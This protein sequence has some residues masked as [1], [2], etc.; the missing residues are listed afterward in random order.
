MRLFLLSLGIL[1]GTAVIG[2]VTIRMVA[3]AAAGAL[4]RLPRGLWLSTLVLL[5][6]SAT[7]EG[8]LRA[9]RQDLQARLRAC[10]TATAFLG[11]NFLAVQAACWVAWA[12]PMREALRGAGQVYLLTGFYVLTGLHGLHVTGG[13]LPLL[14][15]TRR[16]WAGRYSA[17]NHA[18]IAYMATYWHFLDAVWLVLFATLLLSR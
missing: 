9:A 17:H 16:A 12:G 5:A 8:A 1:F 18:G 13:L 7:V 10:L 6:S 2:Y 3:P 4:P 15:V 11:A 14:I